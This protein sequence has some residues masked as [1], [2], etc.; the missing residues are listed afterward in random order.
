[1]RGCSVF[2]RPPSISGLPVSSRRRRRRGPRRAAPRRCRPRRPARS[3][4]RR[5]RARTRRD[6]VLSE[7][8]SSARRSGRS[9]GAGGHRISLL[10]A[11]SPEAEPGRIRGRFTERARPRQTQPRT[12]AARAR[13]GAPA[14]RTGASAGARSFFDGQ[15]GRPASTPNTIA[16]SPISTGASPRRRPRNPSR[17]ARRAAAAARA[18][19]PGPG[20]RPRSERRRH[21]R[22]R[23]WRSAW[24][25]ARARARHSRRRRRRAAR[26]T[27]TTRVES[28][29]AGARP[30]PRCGRRPHAIEQQ[31]RA[32]G[33]G[34]GQ[35]RV[36][37]AAREQGRRLR[38]VHEPRLDAARPRLGE[39]A[40][41]DR[42]LL[43]GRREIGLVGA[44]EMR[45][46][47]LE[48]ERRL[49]R[50]RLEQ[51]RRLLRRHAHPTHPGV[52]LDLH[53]PARA[54][55]ARGARHGFE[56]PARGGRP[57]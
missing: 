16:S 34:A 19:R 48:R 18:A 17:R 52:D 30:A 7:T 39:H 47:A 36:E 26:R 46:D 6:P 8:E 32:H 3:R 51:R 41:Q 9:R 43:E 5:A 14:A 54:P 27:C 38:R 56:L 23:A 40:A 11:G 57:A 20:S 10:T 2:T 29:I 4:A 42:E 44:R 50:H 24:G 33:A 25:G 15:R 1:M 31:A 49:A 37:L 35:R 21:S 55:R 45:E 53:G 12:R 22:A 13:R 28:V